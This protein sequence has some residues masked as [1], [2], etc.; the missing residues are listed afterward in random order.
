MSTEALVAVAVAAVLIVAVLLAVIPRARAR[1]RIRKDQLEHRQ[2]ADSRIAQAEDH[3]RRAEIAAAT[4]RREEADAR[5]ARAEAAQHAAI[6]D[7]GAD[8]RVTPADV[9]VTTPAAG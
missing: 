3:E 9:T 4:A 7:P 2:A 6:G 1:S 5:V 8:D